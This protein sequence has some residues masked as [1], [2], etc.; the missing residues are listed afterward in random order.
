MVLRAFIRCT[1]A[2]VVYPMF[3][4]LYTF[5]I[6][7]LIHLCSLSSKLDLLLVLG[8][9]HSVYRI[10]GSMCI[11][12]ALRIKRLIID[13]T[14]A[15]LCFYQSTITVYIRTEHGAKQCLKLVDYIVYKY[16]KEAVP[17]PLHKTH[18]EKS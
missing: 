16:C 11:S 1:F 3:F 9:A 2:T 14:L 13:K 12:L 4:Y 17:L 6:P 8:C 10:E 15:N 18:H 5:K 7:I